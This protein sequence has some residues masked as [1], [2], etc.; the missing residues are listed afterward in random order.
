MHFKEIKE[1]INQKL[2]EIWS[3]RR[4]TT[5]KEILCDNAAKKIHFFQKLKIQ[6]VFAK[7]IP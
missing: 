3:Y 6:A 4:Y 2:A 5:P 1:I 7:E